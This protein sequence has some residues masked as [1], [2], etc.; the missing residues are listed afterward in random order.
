MKWKEI[1][2]KFDR[3]L[4][5]VLMLM[6]I[7]AVAN[8][9]TTP[10]Q[11]DEASL[12]P[13]PTPVPD[14][15]TIDRIVNLWQAVEFTHGDHVDYAENCAA[16]HHHSAQGVTPACSQCHSTS[17]VA[18]SSTTGL[19]LKAAYHKQCIG[20]HQDMGSGPE[21]CIECHAKRV[22]PNENS[23]ETQATE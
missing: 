8:A 21:K 10:S 7:G 6:L 9:E 22:K 18:D 3:A 4:L 17:Q 12:T 16:C 13:T 23:P 5:L 19:S 11:A 2:R 14:K 15:I 20:C 1:T